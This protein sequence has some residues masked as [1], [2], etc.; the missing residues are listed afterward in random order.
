MVGFIFE[1]TEL[2]VNDDNDWLT[3]RLASLDDNLDWFE[4]KWFLS[5]VIVVVVVVVLAVLVL[6]LH[7]SDWFDSRN[8][9]WLFDRLVESIKLCVFNWEHT[10]D[11]IVILIVET[12]THDDVVDNLKADES[13]DQL[14]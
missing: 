9:L 7:L 11:D 10:D 12:S 8:R 13:W 3:N 14:G 1:A 5:P 2:S 6:I 4:L